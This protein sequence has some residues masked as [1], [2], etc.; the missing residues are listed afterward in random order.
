MSY[1][2]R[3]GDRFDCDCDCHCQCL[4]YY[5][6]C[7]YYRKYYHFLNYSNS[8][9]IIISQTTYFHFTFNQQEHADALRERIV[10]FDA[11]VFVC[12]VV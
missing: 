12:L 5:S 2:A 6:N 1:F 11:F 3:G 8:T 9:S 4:N 10:L 7:K